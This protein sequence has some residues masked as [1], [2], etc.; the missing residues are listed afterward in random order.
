MKIAH[1]AW[2]VLLA[3]SLCLPAKDVNPINDAAYDR[4]TEAFNRKD[5]AAA[6]AGY[7]EALKKVP[8]MHAYLNRASAYVGLGK[9]DEALADIETAIPLVNDA[10]FSDVHF[11]YVFFIRGEAYMGKKEYAKAIDDFG[12]V[13]SHTERSV[14]LC[15]LRGS[16][17]LQLGRLNEARRDLAFALKSSPRNTDANSLM[18]KLCAKEGDQAATQ[19]QLHNV[20]SL[21]EKSPSEKLCNQVAW[22]MATSPDEKLRDGRRAVLYATQACEL[23]EWKNATIVDTLAAACAEA[24]DFANAVK[25]EQ[26]YLG[27]PGLTEEQIQSAQKRL[28]LF[29]RFLPYHEAN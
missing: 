28:D 2:F 29:Q 6:V 18:L 26:D 9:Y 1:L 22:L 14:P 23:S 7:T 24:G 3:S 11:R 21:I 19:R 15:L 12:Y 25:W 10:I 5:W 16:C 13:I 27:R 17:E 4:A 8:Y 20:L